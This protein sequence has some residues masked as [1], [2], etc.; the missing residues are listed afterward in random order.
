MCAENFDERFLCWQLR[1]QD[2]GGPDVQP[3]S[4]SVLLGAVLLLQVNKMIAARRET[5]LC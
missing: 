2:H 5:L 3:T 4:G 1:W